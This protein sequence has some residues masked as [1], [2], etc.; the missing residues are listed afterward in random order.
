MTFAAA[1]ERRKRD[2][3]GFTVIELAVALLIMLIVTSVAIVAVGSLLRSRLRTSAMTLEAAIRYMYNLSVIHNEAHRL[4][5]DLDNRT[6]WGEAVARGGDQCGAFLLPEDDTDA[7]NGLAAPAGRKGGAASGGK[8]A[9]RGAGG[10]E[11]TGKEGNSEE[12]GQAPKGAGRGRAKGAG[13]REAGA[14]MLGKHKL[15]KGVSFKGVLTEH[16]SEVQEDGTASLY[17]F[18][19]G[20]V[21]HAYIYLTDGDSTLTIESLPLQGHA[22]LHDEELDERSFDKR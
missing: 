7:D 12:P 21:E 20:Y 6:W 16:H 10:R 19:T 5:V 1:N 14:G 8:G 15:P 2:A 18:P 13:A 11:G 22:V 3:G 17:F 4:V 9:A